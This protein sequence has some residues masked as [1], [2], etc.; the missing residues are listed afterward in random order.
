MCDSKHKKSILVVTSTFPRWEN[1]V[2]PP[3]VLELCKRL[4]I[5]E[6]DIDVL[7]PHASGAKKYE[8]IN[9]VNVY[10]YPYFLSKYEL[11]SYNS[12]IL[13][14]LKNNKLI[15][16]LV[17]FFLVAQMFAIWKKLSDKKYDLIHAHWII[18]QGFL[19]VVICKY[20]I[21]KSPKILCTS[22]GSDL[23]A[24]Q[25]RFISAIRRWTLEYVDSM[26]VVS[27]YMKSLCLIDSDMSNKVHV[28]SMGV[29]LKGHFI[30]K[31]DIYR[32][33][34]RIIF[35]G[36]L[37][38]KKGI[39]YLLDAIKKLINK[40]E[41][42]NLIVVGDGSDRSMLE[43]KCKD[44]MIEQ[45]VKFQG[46]VSQDELPGLYSSA[47]IFVMPS[48]DQEGLGLVA[49]EAMGCGCAVITSAL[50]SVNDIIEDG[51]NGIM[52][53]SGDSTSLAETIKY[54]LSNSSERDRMAEDG[55]RSVVKKFDWQ[56]VVYKY[57]KIIESVCG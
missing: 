13:A 54:L 6:F 39:A 35:V 18:P 28:C 43:N 48:I 16:M 41:K 21:K 47:S 49:V 29:D 8:T 38:E 10:R 55:R 45:H 1:D 57:Q 14:N 12:G 51:V 40:F 7:A 23:F 22:H 19:C 34:Y 2:T 26:T 50:G 11:L 31:K 15:Y 56:I 25:S 4:V 52:V 37:V 17:P 5:K 33:R 36:R 3:F 53:E 24:L 30:P 9:G 46:S 44:L 32:D 42:I 27:E 20:F